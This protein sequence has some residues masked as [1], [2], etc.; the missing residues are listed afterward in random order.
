MVPMLEYLCKKAPRGPHAL[1]AFDLTQGYALATDVDKQ[2]VP[3][4]ILP[5]QAETDVA[6]TL[7]ENFRALYGIF[8]RMTAHEAQ[9]KQDE[10]NRKPSYR[11]FEKGETA[12]TCWAKPARGPTWLLNSAPLAVLCSAISVP[13]SSWTTG[14]TSLLS[15]SSRVPVAASLPSNRMTNLRFEALDKCCG[16]KGPRLRKGV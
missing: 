15:K 3:F 4:S 1:S 10:L 6:K 5:G 16:V 7:F 8:S 9:R 13:M 12:F 11:I 14:P 2:L